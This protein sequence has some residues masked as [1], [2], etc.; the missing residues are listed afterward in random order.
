MADF[1]Y[2]QTIKE[3]LSK[4][5]NH[6]YCDVFTKYFA[7]KF[8]TPGDVYGRGEGIQHRAGD[9]DVADQTERNC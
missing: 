7:K 5:C 9:W 1:M 8:E 2:Y 6:N 4:S 3:S